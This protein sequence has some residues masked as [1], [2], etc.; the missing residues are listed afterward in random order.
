MDGQLKQQFDV[1][2]PNQVWVSEITYIRA[3]EGWLYLAEVIDL[4]SRQIVGRSMSSRI[5]T[6]L[7]INALFM[8]VWRRQPEGRVI[9]H[10]NQGCQ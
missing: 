10:S 6:G 9:V 2:Q 5:D 3:R 7:V 4:F 8:T 1:E